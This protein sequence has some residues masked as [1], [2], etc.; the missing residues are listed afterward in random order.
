MSDT[1]LSLA[2]ILFALTVFMV[3]SSLA[4]ATA[5]VTPQSAPAQIAR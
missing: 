5:P 1:V 2:K 4:N 3:A